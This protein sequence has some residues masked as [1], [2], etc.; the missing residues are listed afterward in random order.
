MKGYRATLLSHSILP[1]KRGSS[2]FKA[3]AKWEMYWHS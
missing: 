2:P 3:M 1:F